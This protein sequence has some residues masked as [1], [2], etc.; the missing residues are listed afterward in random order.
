MSM[1]K[2]MRDSPRANVGFC[3]ELF[4]VVEHTCHVV[5]CRV[6]PTAAHT[7]IT[8]LGRGSWLKGQSRN[9]SQQ[10]R[11]KDLCLPQSK[12]PSAGV[13]SQLYSHFWGLVQL[14]RQRHDANKWLVILCNHPILAGDTVSVILRP[15]PL[16]QWSGNSASRGHKI[17]VIQFMIWFQQVSIQRLSQVASSH[18]GDGTSQIAIHHLVAKS[19]KTPAPT[20][21]RLLWGWSASGSRQRRRPPSNKTLRSPG[22]WPW[23]L[24]PLVHRNWEDSEVG[25][26]F[27]LVILVAPKLTLRLV[28]SGEILNFVWGM[29]TTNTH[30]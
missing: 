12:G 1:S 30:G 22:P 29:N 9:F 20:G 6:T 24:G 25:W 5:G 4:F 23:P 7:A 13:K 8:A 19:T 18:F 14:V 27:V 28:K 15:Q 2:Y 17:K 3:S 10:R 21:A 16:V 26:W 11:W